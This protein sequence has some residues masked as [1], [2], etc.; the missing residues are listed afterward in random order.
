LGPHGFDRLFDRPE[1][2]Q[3]RAK[4]V[5]YPVIEGSSSQ[6]VGPHADG[7]F[8]TFVSSTLLRE[9]RYLLTLFISYSKPL[10]TRA[11]KYR[12][13]PASGSTHPQL[14]EHWLSTKP[15]LVFLKNA[16]SHSLVLEFV[17]Q[18]LM[19]ATLHR[20]VSPCGGSPRYS[21]P[22]FHHI[23]MNLNLPDHIL[24]RESFARFSLKSS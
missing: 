17:T 7:G 6:G 8:L 11:Y 22:F 10:I 21:V 24:A 16:N 13:C 18:G 12:T 5:K 23:G 2:I 3:H 14:Q 4:I 20:V 19:R 9:R 1:L 15:T